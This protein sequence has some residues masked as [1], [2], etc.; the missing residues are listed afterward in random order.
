M[1]QVC[2]LRQ[3]SLKT[4]YKSIYKSGKYERMGKMVFIVSYMQ[5]RKKTF[6]RVWWPKMS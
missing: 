5:A 4:I 6:L 1:I 2:F 3:I